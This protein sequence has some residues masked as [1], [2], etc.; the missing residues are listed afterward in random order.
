MKFADI[1]LSQVPT[2]RGDPYYP[3]QGGWPT[4]RYFNTATGKQ[5]APYEKKTNL[6][7]CQ[8]LGDVTT[9]TQFVEMVGNT[10][11]MASTKDDARE[12]AETNEAGVKE[13]L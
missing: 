5:G 10:K 4:I 2:L 12:A 7:V 13:E 9:M 8:E 1:N 6:P 3:G 11:L